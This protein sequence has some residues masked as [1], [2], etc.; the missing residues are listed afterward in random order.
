MRICSSG[1][2]FFYLHVLARAC[3]LLDRMRA[4][5]AYR[6]PALL[7]V[8]EVR[9]LLRMAPPLHNRVSFPTV[10]SWGRRLHAGLFL[11]VAAIDG[12][13]LMGH[14]HRGKGAKDRY[15]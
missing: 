8:Q 10:S 4:P 2:R 13:R 9:R 14:V 5:S 12:P 3:K 15:I 6:L 7:S 11:Q 1:L